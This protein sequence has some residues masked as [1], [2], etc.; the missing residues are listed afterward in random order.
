MAVRTSP[1]TAILFPDCETRARLTDS[2]TVPA[3]LA[4][5]ARPVAVRLRIARRPSLA[6]LQPPQDTCERARVHVKELREVTRREP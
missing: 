5:K 2:S 1:A 4:F 3:R 6:P